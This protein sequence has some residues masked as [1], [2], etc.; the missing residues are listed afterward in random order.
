[1]KRI[2]VKPSGS[3]LFTKAMQVV[4]AHGGRSV[5]RGAMTHAKLCG[6]PVASIRVQSCLPGYVMTKRHEK[7]GDWAI[8]WRPITDKDVPACLL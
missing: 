3:F 7:N 8:S 1:M 4:A 2:K 5:T 6:A